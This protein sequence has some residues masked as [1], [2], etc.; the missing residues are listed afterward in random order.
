MG[1]DGVWFADDEDPR[2][3]AI[4]QRTRIG[5]VLVGVPVAVYALWWVLR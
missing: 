3:I 2:F 1:D 4:N 5:N